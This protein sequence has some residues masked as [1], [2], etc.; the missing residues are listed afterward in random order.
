[1]NC[2]AQPDLGRLVRERGVHSLL[3]CEVEEMVG[4]GR[5]SVP[6]HK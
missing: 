2:Q 3:L 6:S 1:M 4:Q 5:A